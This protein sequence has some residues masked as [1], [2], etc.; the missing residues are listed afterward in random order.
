[1][2]GCRYLA[3]YCASKGGIVNLTKQVA[4]DYARDRIHCNALCPGCR[5]PSF[6]AF[7]VLLETPLAGSQYRGLL[8]SAFLVTKTA[9]TSALFNTKEDSDR[10]MNLTPWGTWGDKDDVAK[11]ALFLASEDA[12][13]VTGVALP[14]D[15]G[16]LAQ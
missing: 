12:A 1:V 14:V 3:G 7:A 15:G 4:I 9:M 6:L 10:L 8:T 11:G 5:S 13:W 16:M 2:A